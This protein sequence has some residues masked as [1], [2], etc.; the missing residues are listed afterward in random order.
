M[1]ALDPRWAGCDEPRVA[2]ELAHSLLAADAYRHARGVAQQAGRLANAAGLAVDQRRRLLAAA[3]LADIGLARP[4]ALASL[5]GA[6][7]LRHAGRE[8]LAR[9]VAHHLAAAQEARLRGLPAVAAEFPWPA[10]ADARILRL[11]DIA[12][13]TTAQDGSRASPAARLRAIVTVR[14][15]ADPS[16]RVLVSLVTALADDPRSRRLIE[17]IGAR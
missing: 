5:A 14:G 17:M 3:W 8:S 9:I 10:G 4:P 7:A 1:S 16:V 6:R 2:R 12:A 15:P 11:L 13:L